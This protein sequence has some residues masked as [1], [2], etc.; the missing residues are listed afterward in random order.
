MTAGGAWAT[1]A[2]WAWVWRADWLRTGS[3]LWM[4]L[5]CTPRVGGWAH[6]T[7]K[8]NAEHSD[9]GRSGLLGDARRYGTISDH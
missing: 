5:S 1:A 2:A 7:L 6:K 9:T 3:W 8:T 4:A